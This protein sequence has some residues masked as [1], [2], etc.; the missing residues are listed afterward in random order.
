LKLSFKRGEV[1]LK[2]IEEMSELTQVLAKIEYVGGTDYWH[3]R[4]LRPELI[5]ELGD[6]RAILGRLFS[7]LDDETRGQVIARQFVK[8]KKYEEWWG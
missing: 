8:S 6:V 2:A 7:E 5:E 3:G 4:D 1:L